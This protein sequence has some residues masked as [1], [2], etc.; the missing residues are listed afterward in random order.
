[1]LSDKYKPITWDDFIGQ[2]VIPEIVAAC[3]ESDLFEYGGERWL[4]E[5]DGIAGCGKTTAAYVAPTALGIDS[6]NVEK[7]DSR[8]VTI[9]EFRELADTM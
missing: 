6:F 8:A 9:A 1:M 2:P 4:F 7:I 3:E 5:S